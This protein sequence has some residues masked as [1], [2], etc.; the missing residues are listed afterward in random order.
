MAIKLNPNITSTAVDKS[1]TIKLSPN[2]VP[3]VVDNTYNPC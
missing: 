3:T 2:T 1:Y